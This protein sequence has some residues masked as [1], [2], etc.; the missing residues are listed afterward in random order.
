MLADDKKDDDES[1]RSGG[2]DGSTI[3]VVHFGVV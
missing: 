2:A 1:N 3:K